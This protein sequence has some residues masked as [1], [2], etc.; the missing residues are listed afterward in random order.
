MITVTILK[1][2]IPYTEKNNNGIFSLIIVNLLF[3][4][5]KFHLEPFLQFNRTIYFLCNHAKFAYNN[6]Q[7]RNIT[8]EL[9]NEKRL[10]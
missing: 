9:R 5:S 2:F 3:F 8:L 6:I 10:L 7:T 4:N 1:Y